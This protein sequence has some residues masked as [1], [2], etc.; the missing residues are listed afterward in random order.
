MKRCSSLAVLVRLK[1]IK[2]NKTKQSE[3]KRPKITF[4]EKK[5]VKKPQIKTKQKKLNQ[6]SRN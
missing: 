6:L 2:Q 5:H 4:K 3:K 1:R